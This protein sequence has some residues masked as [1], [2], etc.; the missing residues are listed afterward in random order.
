MQSLV[1]AMSLKVEKK[2]P[3]KIPVRQMGQLSSS[4]SY[5][6]MFLPE[7]T[8]DRRIGKFRRIA[9]P[10]MRAVNLRK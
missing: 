10:A 3:W 6:T 8:E 5:F 2:Y 9:D 4:I 1:P 7:E